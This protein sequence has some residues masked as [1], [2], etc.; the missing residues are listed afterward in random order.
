MHLSFFTATQDDLQALVELEAI[1]FPGDPWGE[2]ALAAHLNSP[3]TRT[4]LVAEEGVLKGALL[5][6]LIAPEFE[7]LRIFTHPCARRQGVAQLLL[8]NAHADLLAEG[9]TKGFLEVRESNAPAIGLYTRNGYLPNGK[10][11]AYYQHPT[12]DALLMEISLN[13]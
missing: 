2:L 1:C 9:F 10:R 3:I 6:Q 12:E 5:L 7:V 11:T 8:T 4:L 13:P